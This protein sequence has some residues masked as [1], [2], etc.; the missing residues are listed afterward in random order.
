MEVDG[1]GNPIGPPIG[2]FV[3]AG[4]VTPQY[5][6]PQVPNVSKRLLTSVDPNNFGPRLG[7]AYSPFDS[8]RLVL[9]G[10]YGVFARAATGQDQDERQRCEMSGAR[11]H[12]T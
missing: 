4:N 10:G 6:L 12:C 1:S 5:D 9:R 2:G 3:Q 8:G 11:L 7:F